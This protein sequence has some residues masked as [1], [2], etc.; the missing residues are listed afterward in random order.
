MRRRLA[1]L[2]VILM[3]LSFTVSGVAAGNA[4]GL[5][6]KGG[7]PPGILKRFLN[8]DTHRTYMTEIKDIDENENR[9]TI[10]EGTATFILLVA[11]DAKIESNGKRI[12]L[13]DLEVNDKV[14]LKLNRQNTVTEIKV[15]EGSRKS[16]RVLT[17]VIVDIDRDDREFEVRLSNSKAEKE[18]ELEKDTVIKIDG[19][20]K[21]LKD[22]AVGMQ[23]K[24]TFEDGEAMLVEA[25]AEEKTKAEVTIY[26]IDNKNKTVVV[27]RD[28]VYSMYFIKDDS[29]IYIDNQIKS[30][31]DL[32]KGMTVELHADGLDIISLH[33]ASNAPAEL[34][35]VIKSI[36]VPERQI[37]IAYSSKVELYSLAPGAV[38]KIDGLAKTIEDLKVDMNAVVRLK[39]GEIVEISVNNVLATVEGLLV[40]KDLGNYTIKLKINNEIK[41]YNVNKEFALSAI[42][43]G[44]QSVVYIKDGLVVAIGAK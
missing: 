12:A 24:V 10:E 18:I 20:V 34:K 32:A 30:L 1:G 35:A 42:P 6:K 44:M 27:E 14:Y 41:V 4:Q 36:N 43:V 11:N 5:E 37:T 16:H 40:G 2:M 3:V 28:D 17:G 15:L 23:V 9:I 31:A 19:A 13:E 26:S 33:A 29:R 21:E 7:L 25:A 39:D 8:V 38:I 22:L